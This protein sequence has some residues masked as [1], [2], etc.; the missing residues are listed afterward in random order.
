MNS[1]ARHLVSWEYGIHHRLDEC[2]GGTGFLGRGNNPI[3]HEL[4]L[5]QGRSMSLRKMRFA[6]DEI[7]AICSATN[8]I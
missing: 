3:A 5:W 2:S 8:V 7:C 6:K 4:V 1:T